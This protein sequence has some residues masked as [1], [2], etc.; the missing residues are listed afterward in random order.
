MHTDSDFFAE[1]KYFCCICVFISCKVQVKFKAQMLLA[2]YI[3][4]SNSTIFVSKMHCLNLRYPAL[5][6][7]VFTY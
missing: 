5:Q 7:F 4:Y 1:F 6:I 2:F 3:D